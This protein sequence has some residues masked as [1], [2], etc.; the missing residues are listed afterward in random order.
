MKPQA[1]NS[2]TPKG[3]TLIEIMIVIAVI[4]ILALVTVPKYTAVKEHYKLDDSAQMAAGQLRYAKQLAMDRRQTVYVVFNQDGVEVRDQDYSLVGTSQ[5]WPGGIIFDYAE[6]TWLSEISDGLTTYGWGFSYSNRGFAQGN[7]DIV[8]T[9]SRSGEK[10]VVNIA[11]ATGYI[12][13][14]WP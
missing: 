13:V 10:A 3:F 11:P 1:K 6:N 8:L 4:G 5:K 12:T 2:R 14:N 7:G 9:S